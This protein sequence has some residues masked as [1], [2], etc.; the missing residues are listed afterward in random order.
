MYA[1]ARLEDGYGRVARDLRVSVTDHCD[2]RCVYCMPEEG[3]DWLDAAEQL[4]FDEIERL[5]SIFVSLGVRT[6]RL[7]GGEPL[8]RPKLVELVGALAA[9]DLDD[10]SMT[11]NATTL[12][13]HA[14]SLAAA[15]LR[16][17]NVSLDT[18]IRHRFAQMT[19]RDAL[20]RVLAG[21]DA[22]RRVGLSPVK[23]N[24]VLV[25]GT[26]DDEILDFVEFARATGCDVRFI[27]DMPLGGGGAWHPEI[28]VHSAG[29]LEGIAQR[30]ALVPV[31][32]GSE[33]A[34][35]YR[36]ADGAPGRIGLISSVTEPFCEQ[37]D[38][39]RLTADGQLR[40]CLF[41]HVE[42]DLRTPLRS[43]ATDSDL[44]GLIRAAVAA[45]EPGHMIGR[46]N[47][48]Q[49]VRLMSRIGG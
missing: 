24:V 26:N 28:V 46:A 13:R 23:I 47:F 10:L 44:A 4:T 6:V 37:C 17:V 29:I 32:R 8:M 9:L 45:K 20:D 15:G 21:I 25:G 11:T 39:L 42:T 14:E 7:T 41:A 2:L 38:R 1:P 43:G 30:H 49:P 33:P 34:A 36:F 35:G 48:E 22:A 18:L 5:V 27:E 12:A 3:L 40:T 31:E 16:R 19:R